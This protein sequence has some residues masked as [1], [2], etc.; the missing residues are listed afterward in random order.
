MEPDV[1]VKMKILLSTYSCF[2]CQ[3]SEP[4]NAWRS[5]NEALRE[6][7]V[8]AVIADA[9]RYRE[10]TEPWLEKNPLPNFHPVWVKLNPVLQ[11]LESARTNPIYYHLWQEHLR[12]VV[13]ELHQKIKFDLVHHVTYGRYW[14][15]SGLRELNLPFIWGPVGAAETPPRSF[16]RELPLRY[17]LVE[18][19]RDSARN[20]C[21]HTSALRAT[22]QAATI[23]I[24]VTR[25]TCDAL[26]RLGARRVEQ[27]PQMALTD[28]DLAQFAALPAPPPGPLRAICVGR[29][30]YWKGFYLAIRAFAEFAK[31]TQDGELWIV[32]DGPFRRNLEATAAATGVG[33][34]V[35]FLGSLPKYSDVLE[36][37]GQSHV[38]LHPALHEGFGNVCLEALAAGRPVGCLDIGGPASQIT[39]ETGFAAPATNPAEAVSALAGFLERIDRDRKLLASMSA[40][41]R[42]HVQRNFTMERINEQMRTYYNEAIT[43]HRSANNRQPK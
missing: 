35:K 13:R 8:W 24:G 14:S 36:K 41:T 6:H 26:R 2:P 7:E 17:R 28:S 23:A 25:E 31:K 18:A 43:E 34:R 29:H 12:G 10:L 22:A 11:R 15:P 37:L 30:V 5:I 21:E 16:V 40:A 39:P 1:T 38:L 27:M 4:G 3:T 33:P 20:I 42:A 19:A 32:N 9:H